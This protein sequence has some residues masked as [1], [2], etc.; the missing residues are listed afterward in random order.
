MKSSNYIFLSLFMAFFVWQC[1]PKSS[2]KQFSNGVQLLSGDM[3][4]KVQF[5]ADN[6][7]RILKWNASGKEEKHSLSVIMSSDSTVK[8]DIQ[9]TKTEVLLSTSALKLKVEKS[10]GDVQFMNASE[11]ELLNEKG[12]D[13]K[14]AGIAGDPGLNVQQ[15]FEFSS[16]EGIYGLGQHQNGLMNY[17]GHRVKLVQTNTN[18]V[19]PFLISTKNYG[20]L[21]DNYSKTVF[22][23]SL[24]N[25]SLWSDVADNIDYYFIAGSN[26]D[27]V[28]A[29]YRD[30]TGQAPMYGKWAYG[31]WQSK[32]HYEDRNELL[33]VAAEYRK[34][35]IPIDNII[36]DWD[37]WEGSE[38]WNQIFFDPKKFP[39]PKQMLEKLHKQNFHVMVS[40]WC[41]FGPNTEVYKDMGKNGFLLP[42][43]GWAKFKYF[44]VYNPA[45]NNLF[46]KYMNNGFFSIGMDG[47]W[48]D[49]TEPDIINANSKEST[50][51]EMKRM[52]ANHLGSFA[53]YL[54]PYTLLATEGVY[55]NQRKVS[56][57]KRVYILTRS[58][59]AGQQRAAATTWSGDIGASWSIYRNQITAGLN[60][61]MSG[62]PY[63]TFDIGAFVLGSYGGVFTKGGKDP[64]YQEL[65]TRMFQFGTFCPI[66]RS[67]GSETPREIWEFGN[68]TNTLVKFDNLRYRL[69]PY[70]YSL[71]SEVTNKGYTI[72]RGLA[73]D[74]P[75]DKKTFNINDQ[76]M[77]GPAIMV[78]PVTEYMLHRPP[79]SSIPVTPEYFKTDEGQTGLK[80][81]YFKD[82]E[83]KQLSLEKIDSSININWYATGRPDYVTDSTMSIRWKG[84]LIPPQTGKYQ[85]HIKCYGPKEILIDGKSLPF[86][87]KSVEAYTDLIELE[88]GKEYD[89][90]LNT[91]N[92]NPGALRVELFWKTPEILEKEKIEEKREQTRL[93]YLPENTQW[94]DFWTGETLAG[95]QT[96]SADAPIDKIPLLVKAGSIIPMGPFVQYASEKPAEAIEIRVYP[97]ANGGFSLYEDE[98]D[99]Y[100][101]E[102]GM[103]STIAFQWDD[104]NHQLTIGN[105]KGS[106]SGML[107][108]RSFKII[109]VGKSK[110]TGIELTGTPDKTVQ[111]DG[112]EQVVQM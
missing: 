20:I 65:Y 57:Q 62:I 79:M 41:S 72:Q 111:Y 89:F 43:V 49:S 110:G 25:T 8:V 97:G 56:D 107:D 64:A 51:Y 24:Q 81:Q 78:C 55:K 94:L 12:T 33:S 7:V 13:F 11:A 61:S 42:T 87:Y 106:F 4:V 95:G 9:E 90:A 99:N 59:F 15:N 18:A 2:V 112:N 74:F 6:T 45:A 39:E 48:M 71:A 73:M 83:Y 68:F 58:A 109:V 70:I 108:K 105:R 85:F 14:P 60:H 77:F 19:T 30:L 75:E 86:V 53:R 17:R 40:V 82:M 67:H 31:Y 50:E 80:A 36:Q 26:M 104:A 10:T 91:Q 38:N 98:N 46:W 54:N 3:N 103:Y 44:D 84:K 32:E 69:M 88:A 1:S 35:K 34:R 102:K 21:W 101:Y 28:I 93:V 29:G 37:T 96:I 23:D 76:F 63:W 16:D 66:F 92:S 5:Y 52:A 47:W 22:N 27:A 100:N